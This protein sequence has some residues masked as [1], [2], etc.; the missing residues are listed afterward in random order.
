MYITYI[1]IYIYSAEWLHSIIYHLGTLWFGC[2]GFLA[3]SSIFYLYHR[4]AK[5]SILSVWRLLIFLTL[6]IHV[7]SS[8]P[9][10]NYESL[11]RLCVRTRA[12]V[13]M[14]SV[15]IPPSVAS[16]KSKSKEEWNQ[17]VCFQKCVNN[18]TDW[19]LLGSFSLPLKV[20]ACNLFTRAFRPNV[21][22]DVGE[23]NVIAT[24][25]NDGQRWGNNISGKWSFLWSFLHLNGLFSFLSRR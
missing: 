16:C 24:G 5:E 10:T 14:K 3:Y 13:Q 20:F 15:A 17:E 8:R 12:I 6:L 18:L 23:L 21:S 19:D 22:N 9:Q 2:Y 4:S 11:T 1:Y 7:F 25:M